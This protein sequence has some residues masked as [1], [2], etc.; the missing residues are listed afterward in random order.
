VIAIEKS[1][2]NSRTGSIHYRATR[3]N[4]ASATSSSTSRLPLLT[5]HQP[6]DEQFV[7]FDA[8]HILASARAPDRSPAPPADGIRA[9]KHRPRTPAPRS[10]RS[11]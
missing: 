8:H 3:A 1:G 4:P 2:K 6:A 10:T 11:A 9:G 5:P 7:L